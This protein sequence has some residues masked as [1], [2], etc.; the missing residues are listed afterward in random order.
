MP[1]LKE[2]FIVRNLKKDLLIVVLLIVLPFAFFIYKF[3]PTTQVWRNAWFDFDSG[4]YENVK[5]FVW[6]LMLKM[7]TLILLSLW[8][9]TCKHRVICSY[10]S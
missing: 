5:M 6:T 1:L 9:L 8:F 2:I 7:L 4:Y 10:Y 3:V